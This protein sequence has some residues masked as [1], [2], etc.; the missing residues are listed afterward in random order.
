MFTGLIQTL[1][2]VVNVVQQPGGGALL[3]I[4]L[5]EVWP[6]LTLGES[7]AVNGVCLTVIDIDVRDGRRITFEL[8]VETLKRTTFLMMSAGTVVN[9]ERA[10]SVGDRLGG[11]ILSGHVDEVATVIDKNPVQGATLFTF[12]ATKAR[13]SEIIPQGS[14]AIDGISLTVVETGDDFFTVSI[15]PYTLAH[16]NLAYREIGDGVHLETDMFG[17]MVRLYVEAYLTRR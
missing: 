2:T 17:K 9:V 8:M 5:P 16:T 15:L 12:R 13:L 6:D 14:V 1:G 7:M 10:L 4:C 3:T 11:H